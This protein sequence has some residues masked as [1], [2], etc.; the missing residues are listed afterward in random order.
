MKIKGVITGDIV[1]SSHIRLELRKK[2]LVAMREIAEDLKSLSDLKIEFFR[3]DSFQ[4]LVEQPEK[5]LLAAVLFRAGLISRTPE[6]SKQ[7][8]DARISIGVGEVN[9]LADDIVVSDG[10]A[11]QFSGKGMDNMK[12]R[13]LVLHTRW[14]PI[15]E[16]L[17][18]STA[19][20][21]DVISGW[22]QAQAEAIYLALLHDI[23]QKEIASQIEKTPQTVSKLL[24]Y[25][26]EDLIKKFLERYQYLILKE[27]NE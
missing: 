27:I 26:K 2:L 22:T 1:S 20:A 17:S 14:V 23:P 12:K 18:I 10:E 21:D 3:G 24:S 15:N 11:F 7:H 19:F 9:F 16:E 13:R 4:I 5:T 25:A 8:W 6:K